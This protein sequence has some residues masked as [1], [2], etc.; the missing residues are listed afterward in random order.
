MTSVFDATVCELGEGPLWHPLRQ[1]LFW[2]DITG[3]TL[4]TQTGDETLAT[5]FDVCVSAA[6]WIDRDRLLIASARD[7]RVHDLARGTS[8]SLC[9]LEADNALTRSND[10]RADPQGGFWIGTMGYKAEA[11][12]GAIYRWYRGELRQL[13]AR[14]TITNAISFTGDGKTAFFTDSAVG[15]VMR[16]AL[17]ASGWP[18]SDPEVFLDLGAAGREPDGAVVDADGLLWIAEWGS[19]HVAAY[20]PDGSLVRTVPFDA[21]NTTC[22]AFGGPDLTTLYC[23][24]A[25]QGLTARERAARPL[26]GMTFAA[27]AIARGQQEHQVIL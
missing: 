2:F 7:L 3:Q 1:Q 24:S 22:P 27:P 23:T 8:Q 10:G 25:R 17:D 18:A 16:V 13:F 19:A 6:G 14:I 21:P 20:A 12:A 26:S 11:G 15:K 5:R 4:Y 9:P